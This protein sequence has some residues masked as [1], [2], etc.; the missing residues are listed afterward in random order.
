MIKHDYDQAFKKVDLIL[1]PTTPTTAFKLG[2]HAADPLAM[3]LADVYTVSANLAG[4]PAISLPCGMSEGLPSGLHLQG[5]AFDE[6]TLLKAA[7]QY[8]QVTQWHEQRPSMDQ[9]ASV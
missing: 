5:R 3:Y 2:Q 9:E 4:I 8:Q 7:H 1:G 6:S